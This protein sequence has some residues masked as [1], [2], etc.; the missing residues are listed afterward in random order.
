MHI[1]S[2]AAAAFAA[3][4]LSL[5]AASTQAAPLGTNAGAVR[6]PAGDAGL[7]HKATWGWRRHCHWHHGY[8]H[9]HWGHRHWPKRHWGH[10]YSYR[11]GHPYGWRF[12]HAWRYQSMY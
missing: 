5:A 2:L 3:L 1:K 10:R 8:R 6:A 12:R 11:W 7:T 9:C 4:A